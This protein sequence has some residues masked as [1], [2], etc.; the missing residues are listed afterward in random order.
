[1]LFR[2]MHTGIKRWVP[3][4]PRPPA[5]HAGDEMPLGDPFLPQPSPEIIVEEWKNLNLP[6]EKRPEKQPPCLHKSVCCYVDR[7]TFCFYE[8]KG[9]HC[10]H[11]CATHTTP[12][13]PSC[14]TCVDEMAIFCQGCPNLI[15]HLNGEIKKSVAEHDAQVAKAAREQVL[16]EFKWMKPMCFGKHEAICDARCAWAV[17]ERCYKSLR[18]QQQE[19]PSTK[20]GEHR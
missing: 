19:H 8:R 1:M 13:A 16:D 12:P 15:A 6:K 10:V 17:R 9:I 18:S 11:Y 4:D 5:A 14:Q 3:H 2:G 7:N 20:G